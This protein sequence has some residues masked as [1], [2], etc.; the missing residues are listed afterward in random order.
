MCSAGENVLRLGAPSRGKTKL[1]DVGIL[2]DIRERE[3]LYH[4][5]G[6][7]E[8]EIDVTKLPVHQAAKKIFDFVQKASSAGHEEGIEGNIE[9]S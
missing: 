9:N 1:N 6:E 5:G 2:L 7:A 8:I 4:Y 3:D